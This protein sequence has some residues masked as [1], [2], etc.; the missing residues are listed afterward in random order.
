MS[1]SNNSTYRWQ[2]RD[3][4]HQEELSSFIHPSRNKLGDQD[5]TAIPPDWPTQPSTLPTPKTRWKVIPI[6]VFDVFIAALPLLFLGLGLIAKALDNISVESS[7]FGQT[8]IVATRYVR[9]FLKPDLI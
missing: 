1:N 7:P 4:S 8:V 9:S 3:D 2:P 5:Q 6:A